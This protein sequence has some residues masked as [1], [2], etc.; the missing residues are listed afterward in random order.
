MRI[1]PLAALV[2]LAILPACPRDPAS[3]DARSPDAGIL[4]FPALRIT[5]DTQSYLYTYLLADGSFQSTD[6][7]ANVPEG[8]RRQVIVV[9]TALSPEKRQSSSVLYVADLTAKREDGSYSYTV[10]SRFRFERDLL[11]EPAK[12]SE[13]LPP[14]CAELAPSPPDR[15]ILYGTSWCGVCKTAAAF[16]RQQGIPFEEKDVEKDPVAQREI[17]CKALKSGTRVSGVPVLDLGG[18]LLSGFDRDQIVAGYAKMKAAPPR[19]GPPPT[20]GPTPAP[21]PGAVQPP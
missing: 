16:M 15:V 10:V 8:A 18:T 11:R 2:I 5:D 9:D 12:S 1:P 6:R 19:G 21:A 4:D 13:A 7:V 3:S 14:E 17:T 20:P